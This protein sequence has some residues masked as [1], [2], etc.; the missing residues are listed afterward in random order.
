M[1]YVCKFADERGQIQEL[2]EQAASETELR[3]RYSKQGLLVYSVRSRGGLG[4]IF[5]G[6]LSLGGKE[7]LKLE[8]FLIFN[9]QFVTLVR[10]GLPILKS[11]DLLASRVA[12]P[13]LRV[14]IEKV[15]DR[16]KNGA[17]LSAAFEEEHIFPKIYVTSVMAGEKSGSLEGVIDRY[18]G[19]QRIALAVRKK[20]LA[21]LVYPIVLVTLVVCVLTFLTSFVVPRFAELYA[22]LD[23]ELPPITQ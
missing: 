18:I 12:Q 10:A 14:H 13:E 8:Q 11:L 19:Y 6:N 9:Q 15:R 21:S 5:T 17:L 22:G 2:V 20:V 4:G 16:V 1:E 23:A 3:D 7:K